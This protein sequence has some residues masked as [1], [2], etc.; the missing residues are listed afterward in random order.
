MLWH[1]HVKGQFL[2]SSFSPCPSIFIDSWNLTQVP[3]QAYTPLTVESSPW[4]RNRFLIL[5][6]LSGNGRLEDLTTV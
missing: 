1:V 2:C 4:S 3:H 6:N 5:G